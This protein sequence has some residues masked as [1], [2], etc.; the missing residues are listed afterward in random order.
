MLCA[1][2]ASPPSPADTISM[3]CCGDQ[4]LV[5]PRTNIAP[6]PSMRADGAE[7]AQ[8]RLDARS[9]E[10]AIHQFVEQ[11]GPKRVVRARPCTVPTVDAPRQTAFS[12]ARA[13]LLEW[14]EIDPGDHVEFRPRA[15]LAIVGKERTMGP[16]ARLWT[17][18]EPGHAERA[19]RGGQVF[20]S[21]QQVVLVALATITKTEPTDIGT[22]KLAGRPGVGAR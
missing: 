3:I 5:S 9:P 16:V 21:D 15:R 4:A 17:L 8:V 14:P 7:E 19:S 10:R 11:Q 20:R 6:S 12:Q 1:R 18:V 2:S 22:I 13:P